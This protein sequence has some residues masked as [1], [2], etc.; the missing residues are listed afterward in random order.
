MKEITL[1]IPAFNEADRI[2]N[3]L[4]I[5][6]SIDLFQKIIV[7]NDGS[8]DNTAQV[9]QEYAEKD[10]RITLIDNPKNQGKGYGIFTAW[11]QSQTSYMLML[12]ADLKGLKPEHIQDL[13]EP[14]LSGQADMTIGLFRKGQWST[15]L[16]HFITPWLSGQRC[17]RLDLMEQISEDASRGYGIETAMTVASHQYHWKIRKV[18]LMGMSHPPNELHRG[19]IKGVINRMKM[20]SHVIRAW[21]IASTKQTKHQVKTRLID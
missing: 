20:Y 15:D 10:N 5:V 17:F 9:V 21:Y 2:G 13:C 6:R 4:S 11:K 1:A 18:F 8:S 3:I 12:D 19:S 7:I 14:V 16:S